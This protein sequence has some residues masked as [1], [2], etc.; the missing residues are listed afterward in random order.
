MDNFQAANF[1]SKFESLWLFSVILDGTSS[2][3]LGPKK[4]IPF[5]AL[6]TEFT[7]RL[8]KLGQWRKLKF[9]ITLGWNNFKNI[10]GSVSFETSNIFVTRTQK[11]WLRIELDLCFLSNSAKFECLWLYIFCKIFKKAI[12]LF[13]KSLT[14]KYGC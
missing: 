8:V 4:K 7:K 2:Q 6:Y 11:I 3:I 10:I 1:Y 14:L 12:Y 9:D 13:V 5:V